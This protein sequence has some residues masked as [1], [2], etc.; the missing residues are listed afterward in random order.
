MKKR[1]LIIFLILFLG[2]T[3]YSYYPIVSLH[4]IRKGGGTTL[5]MW[6]PGLAA[7]ITSLICRRSLKG[8][9]WL[10]GKPKYL[11]LGYVIPIGYAL[12]AYLVVWL[13]GLGGFPDPDFLKSVQKDHP[14]MSPLMAMLSY[15]AN[16]MIVWFIPNSFKPCGEEIGW[17]GFL[18][19]ALAERLSYAKTSLIIGIIWAVWHF[20]AILWTEYSIDAPSWF[21]LPCFT[22]TVIAASFIQTWLRLRS[23][24][25]WPCVIWHN[26]HNAIIQGFFTPITTRRP[27]TLYFIDEFGVA[28]AIAISIVAWLCYRDAKSRAFE[29]F[30]EPEIESATPGS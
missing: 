13:T 16:L 17:R 30:V 14:G 9:G 1:E 21:A 6:S 4:S 24:S 20:P 25:L 19:P 2:L 28:T 8:F 5:L 29:P 26:S 12:V 18:V 11:L 3:I 23:S 22:V 10:P 7:L 27:Y 15:L